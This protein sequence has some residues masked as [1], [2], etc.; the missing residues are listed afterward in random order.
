MNWYS[1]ELLATKLECTLKAR[2][3]LKV[4]RK[5]ENEY[6]SLLEFMTHELNKKTENLNL[7]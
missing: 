5:I 6:L 3:R 7:K 2:F 1:W 4:D